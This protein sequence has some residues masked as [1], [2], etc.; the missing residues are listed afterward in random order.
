MI[1]RHATP[2]AL[3]DDGRTQAT[4][5]ARLVVFGRL[6]FGNHHIVV[7]AKLCLTCR[8]GAVAGDRACEAERFCAGYAEDVAARR[9][10]RLLIELRAAFER[11]ATEAVL[12]R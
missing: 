1:E 2:S 6:E 5:H 8:A 7:V 10:H 4:Q 11:V 3:N 9:D 12:H